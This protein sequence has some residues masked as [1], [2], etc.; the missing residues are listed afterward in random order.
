L[1][2][3]LRGNLCTS[4]LEGLS[5]PIVGVQSIV[6]EEGVAV[7]RFHED[8]PVPREHLEALAPKGV[9]VGRSMLRVDGD[10]WR[11]GAAPS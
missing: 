5:P 8:Q 7:L 3:H 10:G 4:P 9:S 6:S 2:I 11:A 1:A